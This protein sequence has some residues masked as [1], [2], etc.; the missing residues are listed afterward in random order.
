M[1]GGFI[2]RDKK[3]NELRSGFDLGEFA[4]IYFGVDQPGYEIVSGLTASVS[5]QSVDVGHELWMST[6]KPFTAF[7][8]ILCWIC[9]LHNIIGPVRPSPKILGR[10]TQQM[11]DDVVRHWHDVIRNQIDRTR[12]Q[13]NAIKE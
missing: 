11:G 1:T 6:G 9:A 5:D 4:P 13:E 3:E 8:P 10:C 2:S 7:I 12:R